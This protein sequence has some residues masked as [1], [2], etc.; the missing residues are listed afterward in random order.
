MQK[1][2]RLFSVILLAGLALSGCGYTTK[3]NLPENIKT[4]Y[5]E[6]VPNEIDIAQ[7]AKSDR[8]FPIYR[9][10]LEIEIR[11][12]LIERFIFDGHLKVV[13]SAEKADAIVQ[14]TL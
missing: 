5:I 1:I 14:D 13:D 11:N 2:L 7:S 10:G 9:P 3:G 12:A 8:P 4:V 6:K